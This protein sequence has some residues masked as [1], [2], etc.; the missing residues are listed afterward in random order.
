MNKNTQYVNAGVDPYDIPTDSIMRTF[1]K[2]GFEAISV[3][4]TI[5]IFHINEDDRKK[6][7]TL[8]YDTSANLL[9]V[10]ASREIWRHSWI[11]VSGV[12]VTTEEEFDWLMKHLVHFGKNISDYLNIV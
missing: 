10:G 12:K 5:H 2:Y 7:I 11:I 1:L 6:Y 3:H 9:L 4:G 8:S